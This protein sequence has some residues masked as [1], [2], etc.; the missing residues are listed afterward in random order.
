MRESDEYDEDGRPTEVE[1]PYPYWMA[2][3]PVTVAQYG[4]FLAD[5]GGDA[6]APWWT[7]PGRRWRRGEWDSQVTEEWLKDWLK[8]RPADQRGV[9]LQ[10][11]EQARYPNRPVTYICWFEAVAYGRWLDARLRARGWPPSGYEVRLPTEA[12]WER[13]GRGGMGRRFAWGDEAWDE[14]R[15]NIE[16]HI[17]RVTAVGLYPRGATPGDALHD[18][19][20]NVWE[21][22]ASLYR[23]YPYRDDVWAQRSGG[24]RIAGVAWRV[25]VRHSEVRPRRVPQRGRSLTTSAITSGFGWL[26]PYRILVSDFWF[27]ELLVC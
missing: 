23:L 13:A 8:Q 2:R 21:W 6:D 24:G 5:G 25:V 9:P 17:G 10:W 27:L 18:L 3:Y 11:S 14:D 1:I 20:G 19:T 15:A 7:E 16:E 12:E 22:T 26:C 4:A